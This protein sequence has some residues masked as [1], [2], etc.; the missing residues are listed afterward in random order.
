[1]PIEMPKGLPFSV[2]TW[3]P[4]SKRKRYHFLTHAHKDHCSQISLH[5]SFPIYTTQLTKSLIIQHIPQFH[6]S[7]FVEIE[8]G[9]SVVID[10]P[11][12]PFSVTAFDANHCPGAVMFLFE[13]DF[14]NVLHTGDCRLTPEC[15]QKLPMKYIT[16]KGRETE[17]SLDYLFLDCTF[18]SCLLKLPSKH[19]A[20]QQVINCIWKHPHAPVVYLACG[21]LGQEDILVEVSRTFGSKI[22]V[23]RTKNAECFQELSLT[24]PH[25]LSEDVSCRF[26]VLDGFPRLYEK[27]KAMLTE[28][29]ANLQPEPLFIRPSAQWYACEEHAEAERRSDLKLKEAENDQFGVWHVCYSMH[30]SRDEL[31]WALELL[32]PKWVISTTPPCRAMELDYV[33]NHCFT[34]KLTKDSPLWKLLNISTEK[35]TSSQASVPPALTNGVASSALAA[36]TLKATECNISSPIKLS[37]SLSPP[38]CKRPI[39]LFGKARL[40]LQDSVPLDARKTETEESLFSFKEKSAAVVVQVEKPKDVMLGRKRIILQDSNALHEENR[41]E[42]A[43]TDFLGDGTCKTAG[44]SLSF[45]EDTDAEEQFE[46]SEGHSESDVEKSVSCIGPS[47]SFDASIRKLYRSMNV[48]VPRPLPSL[49]ELMGVGKRTKIDSAQGRKL[50]AVNL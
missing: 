29:K 15:L 9:Q 17:G 32:Q 22:Y 35:Y 26:Q 49:V 18:A 47:N 16:R 44:R 45:Q 41:L 42:C 39:T 25:I 6:P 4:S 48:P 8:V 38:S 30:S 43:K 40:V 5:S 11:D 27:A 19:S 13:G 46:K 14:G 10:D 21:L 28:A 50:P 20:I 34:T 31:E 24:A 36:P 23:D 1:M 2:D 12:Y 37:L 3:S 33:R 7:L